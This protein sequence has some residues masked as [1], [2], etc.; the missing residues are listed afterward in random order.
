MTDNQ[1]A[2]P[3]A[4][5]AGQVKQELL[6]RITHGE[7]PPGTRLVELRIAR[8]LNTSQEPLHEALREHEA[9][10]LVRATSE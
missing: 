10:D 2:L 4:S 1:H 3:W 5:M 9:M 7:L 8:D 6:L